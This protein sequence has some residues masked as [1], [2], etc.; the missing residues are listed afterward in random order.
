MSNAR[1]ECGYVS[2]HVCFEC[3]HV[4]MEL[5]SGRDVDV[6]VD[7]EIHEAITLE[8]MEFISDVA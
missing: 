4:G 2:M 7:L 8:R 6:V 1:H 3:V 5:R